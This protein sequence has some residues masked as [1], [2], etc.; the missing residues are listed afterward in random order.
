MSRFRPDLPIYF[1]KHLHKLRGL[2]EKELDFLLSDEH[3]TM[4]ETAFLDKIPKGQ[5]MN[6][7]YK[8]NK[9]VSLQV[10][11]KQ[12]EEN[13]DWQEIKDLIQE[14]LLSVKITNVKVRGE[15]VGVIK[16][17]DLHFGAY[18]DGLIRTKEFSI[19]ILCQKLATVAEKTNKY[20][21]AGVHIHLLG[22]LIES[23][24][25]FNHK[26]SW[27]S[28]DKKMIGAEAIKL[29]CKCLHDYLLSRVYNLNTVKIVAGNHDRT[30]S[31]KSE[32]VDGGAASLISWGLDLMGYEVE[33]NPLIIS[34]EV[35]GIMHIITHGH[36]GISNKSTKEMIWDYGKQGVFNLLC[37]GHL[38]S[39]IEKLSIKE[40]KS[41]KTTRDDCV[42]HRRFH[43]P[44]L[45]TG[46]AYSEYLGYSSN[47]GFTIT[48]NSG[49][50][51]PDVD[52]KV[53]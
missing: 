30:T 7:W 23:F 26:N 41:F 31:D 9:H 36:H 42:D 46:N 33:F 4:S 8:P 28:L 39:I 52:F 34:H 49:N 51:I 37:E 6:Y 15:N 24:T 53:V 3:L 44:S 40:R 11:P 50:G 48:Y 10:K 16:V 27:K 22:D 21:F 45:F 17:A 14:D 32:D 12:P 13:F 35:D 43:C 19:N 20:R 5:V 47:S 2:S 18:V 1:K 25:G 38:H 29:C